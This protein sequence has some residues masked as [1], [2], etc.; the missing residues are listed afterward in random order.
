MKRAIMGAVLG[1]LLVVGTAGGGRTAATPWPTTHVSVWNDTGYAQAT[2]EAMAAWNGV[3]TRV[4]LIPAPSRATARVV[5]G[6]LDSV[7]T[8][9]QVG[10]ATVGWVPTRRGQVSVVRGMSPRLA[11]TVLAHE[12]G[13]VLGLDHAASRCSIMSAVV[14][15]GSAASRG[16]A[17]T[18]CPDISACLVTR[19]DA[20]VLRNLYERRL[21]ALIPPS[22][23]AVGARSAG[24]QQPGV[25]V[26]WTSPASGPGGAILVRVTRDGCPSSP[27]SA[28]LSRTALVTLQP[29]RRQ[30]ARVPVSGPGSWCAGVWVQETESYVTG[31]AALIRVDVP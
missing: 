14:E 3:G 12:L 30:E 19:Q 29:G 31:T 22:V 7:P 16:C 13:H 23:S 11:A 8:P 5:V 28:P 1:A 15:G 4:T 10:L 24:G 18:S 26:R 6:Y 17:R 2:A 27:Y 20:T 21:P 9:D 25:V